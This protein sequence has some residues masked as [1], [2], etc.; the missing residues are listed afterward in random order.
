[1][2]ETFILFDSIIIVFTHWLPVL[3]PGPASRLRALLSWF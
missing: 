1:M 3:D 2:V